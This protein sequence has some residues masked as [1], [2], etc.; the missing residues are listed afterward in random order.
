[1]KRRPSASTGAPTRWLSSGGLSIAIIAVIVI[2]SVAV[3]AF[4]QD[5]GAPSAEQATLDLFAAVQANDVLGVL[6]QLPPGER[7]ELKDG[8]ISVANELQQVG[9]LTSGE[10][11]PVAGPRV[12]VASPLLRTTNLSKDMDA[13][14]VVGG[15]ITVTLPAGA[16][17]LTPQARDDLERHAGLHLDAAGSS[18]TRDFSADPLR[19]VAI[20]EGG[21]WHVSLAYTVAEMVRSSARAEFPEM[22]TGPPSIGATTPAEVVTD[23]FNGYA[24]ADAERLVTLMYPDEARA[25]YDYAPAFLPQAKALADAAAVGH[26]YDVQLNDL[27][28]VVEGEGSTRMVRVTAFDLE[29]RDELKK[30]HLTYDGRCLHL[31]HRIGDDGQPYEKWDACDNDPPKSG[32]AVM[33]RENPVINAAIFGGGVDLPTFVVIERG[34]RWFLS[35]TRT[36][37]ESIAS[38]LA[39]LP[40]DQ[41]DRFAARL[42]DSVRAG[43]GAGLTGTP[44]VG[45]LPIDPANPPTDE[46]RSVARQVALVAACESLT[47]GARAAEVTAA[48]QH[49]L[50]ETGRV[51]KSFLPDAP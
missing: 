2:S 34:G 36:V 29:L 43:A 23:L 24:D 17:P 13:V 28:T 33:P 38:T 44:I 32:D 10:L 9:L 45:E 31:D 8:V 25:L 26:T 5:D 6:E 11:H 22:G 7:K 27:K 15:T 12:E 48:C 42:A 18:F 4:T 41:L 39:S 47:T 35:P 14:D 20:R 46:E 51:D 30:A 50:V 19:V 49:R 3:L 37:L 16:G 1:M 40:A 21:G